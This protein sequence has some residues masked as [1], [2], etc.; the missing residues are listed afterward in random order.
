MP[1]TTN[2]K[3]RVAIQGTKGRR[4]FYEAATLE[5]LD[6]WIDQHGKW[7]CNGS[8]EHEALWVSGSRVEI[9]ERTQLYDDD[10]ERSY[11]GWALSRTRTATRLAS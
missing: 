11:M 4:S 2:A 7:R 8:V 6:S 10:A 1:Q 5:E 3:Y 9:Y